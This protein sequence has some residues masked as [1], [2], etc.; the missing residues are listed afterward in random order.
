MAMKNEIA[1]LWDM[2]GVIV[3]TALYHFTAWQQIFEKRGVKF[4]WA[5]FKRS[6]GRRNETIIPD[7]FDKSI[8]A[9]EIAAIAKEKEVIFRRLGRNKIQ[10]F[11]GV[12]NLIKR[13]AARRVKMALVSSTPARNIEVVL[14][15]L[16]IA[17][18]FQ[19]IISG[20]DVVKGKP[21]PE[22]FL[23]A[24]KRLGIRAENCVVIEDSTAGVSAAKRAGMHCVA[25]TNTRSGSRLVRADLIIDSLET[26]DVDD[27]KRLAL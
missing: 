21:D 8:S 27:L 23:L 10:P 12:V 26:I 2:D 19:T 7:I 4:T 20:E 13:L 9:A 25:I 17:D 18:L 3:D 5:E 6:F 11:P 24:A 22:G 15:G 16:G 1:V 14:S